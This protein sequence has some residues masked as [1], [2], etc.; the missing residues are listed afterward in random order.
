MCDVTNDDVL[1]SGIYRC[2]I[3]VVETSANVDRDSL[4]LMWDFTT[5]SK[6]TLT[7]RIVHARDDALP[8]LEAYASYNITN[9][10]EHPHPEIA[11]AISGTFQVPFYLNRHCL[12]GS[13]DI[14]SDVR[15]V[16]D[17]EG[18]PQ[19]QGYQA[20]AFEIGIPTSLTVDG[21]SPGILHQ[22][23]H[24]LLG[25]RWEIDFASELRKDA[26]RFGWVSP[27]FERER[28][29][30]FMSVPMP[31]FVHF[32]EQPP[33]CLLLLVLVIVLSPCLFVA[34]V[35]LD[36]VSTKVLLASDWIGMSSID[37]ESIIAVLSTDISDFAM[38]PDRSVQG[39]INA[40]YLMRLAKGAL[41][42]DPLFSI[43]PDG[44]SVID[45]N[46]G[47]SNPVYSGII[48]FRIFSFLLIISYRAVS[49]RIVSYRIVSY[50]IV[51]H[52]I[53]S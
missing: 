31:H 48:S 7:N 41:S 19:F 6:R 27:F 14:C 51:S 34:F 18:N 44:R 17:G 47:P 35:A 10:R 3:Q 43:G 9:V 24:G 15:L 21:A 53:V 5:G 26:N 1:L 12:G 36:V 25:S 46:Y 23:G 11:R 45:T 22:Y 20:F 42:E 32:C 37:I 40:L 33:Y 38:L 28:E 49:Y 39:V 8:R 29:S 4:Q 30:C 52:R 2:S 50:R 13:E 16:V